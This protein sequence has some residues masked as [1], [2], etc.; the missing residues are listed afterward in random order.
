MLITETQ[1]VVPAGKLGGQPTVIDLQAI[2]IA[3]GRQGEVAFVTPAKAPE[4]L[5]A[6]ND[7]WTLLNRA[8]AKL[9]AEH[10]EAEKQVDRRK[11]KLLL[12]DCNRILKEKGVQSSADTRQAVIDLDEEYQVLQ[13]T[14]DEIKAYLELIKGKMRSMENSYTSVKKIIGDN[15][16]H[17]YSNKISISGDTQRR[18]PS[19]PGLPQ[20][21]TPPV[22]AGWGTP[23]YGK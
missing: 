3:E 12:E 1:L 21:N 2:I 9:M 5:V 11:A 7:S 18:P 14:R 22:R 15:S 19:S 20:T 8:V 4:L 23:K 13:D 6:F 16:S 17:N 10:T